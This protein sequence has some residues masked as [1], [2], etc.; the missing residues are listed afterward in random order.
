MLRII[1]KAFFLIL[2]CSVSGFAQTIVEPV[3]IKWD[4]QPREYAITEDQTLS[5]F[6][7]DGASYDEANPHFPIYS[8]KI[9]LSTYGDLNPVLVNAQYEPINAPS[10]I[11]FSSIEDI[12]LN[13]SV[14]F[15]RRQPMGVVYF[16]PIRKNPLNGQYERLTSA[17]L[18]INITP[19][20]SPY[21]GGLSSSR[22]NV[23]TSKFADGQI[24]K[25]SIS[26]TGVYKIDYNFLK[27]LGVNVDNIDPRNIQIL[28]NGG[29]ILPE[30][31][32]VAIP[33]DI[34]ENAIFVSGQADG[35]FDAND[36]ILF[37]GIG[38]KNWSFNN[39]A[40]C[41]PFTHRINPYTDDSHYFIKIGS[42][43]GKRLTSNQSL[44]STNYTTTSY[45]ALAHHEVDDVNLMEQEF[46]LPPSGRLW[47]G[48]SFQTQNNRSRT[49]N[50]PF[51][52]RIEGE[53]ITIKSNLAVRAFSTGVVTMRANNNIVGQP[54]ASPFTTQ[55]IYTDYAKSL[56]IPCNSITVNNQ[57]IDIRIDFDHP[58]TAA[59]MWLNYISL[60]AR[61]QLQFT[62]GQMDF[63]DVQSVGQGSA[64]YQLSGASNVTIWDITDPYDV[65][66]QE[67]NANG[68]NINFGA[69]ATDLHQFVAFDNS[70][71]YTPTARGSVANQNLHGITTPPDAIFVYYGGT[72]DQFD[73]QEQTERLA[74]HRRS[75]SN[76]TVDVINVQDIYNEFS[77]GNP[78]ITAIRN[79]CKL[80][81]ERETASN[82]FTHL[83]LF[84]IG[85]FDYKN[86]GDT[87]D[88]SNNPNLI[89]VYET[90]ESLHP[91]NTYTSDDYFAL[92]DTLERMSNYGLL[93]IAVGRLPAANKDEAK[94]FVDKIIK[95]DTDPAFM[96]DWKNRL[97][98]MADDGDNNLHLNDAESVIGS[99]LQNDNTFNIEKVYLDA[100]RSVSTSG[101]NRYPDAKNALLDVIFKG[102][103]V[104]NY[105]GHGGDD[106]WTQE[107]VFTSPDVEGLTNG[108]KLPLFIT[109]TC[110]FGPHDDPTSVSAGELLL[111]NP[112]GGAISVFTT[113]RVVIASHNK[114]LV[115]H[116][117]RVIFK[118]KADG[119]M[120]TT[121]EVM[122]FAKNNA[123]ISP[124]TN[125]RK[126]AL[127]GDP[128]MSLAYPTYNVRTDS[129]NGEVVGTTDTI[130][131]LEKVTISGSIVDD[132]N[133]VN[134]NFSGVIYPT[135]Y[136]KEDRLY[137]L[138][139][140][141]SSYPTAFLV[142]KKI[143]FKGKASVKNGKFS[144]T[145]VVPKDI[146]YSIGLGKIS[147]YAENT[148]TLD[149]KGAYFDLNVGGSYNNAVVDNQGPD[150]KVYM[151]TEDFVRGGITDNNPNLLVELYDENGINTVGNSIGHDLTGKLTTPEGQEE[152]YILNDFYESTQ[153]DYTSGT[154]IYPLKNLQP[155]LHTIK[156]KAWD[157]Y[158]NPGEGDTEFVVAESADL[159]LKHVLNYP[160]PF[161]TSTNF[162]FEHNYPYQSLDVQV[163]IYTVSG[164]L[165]K[166]INHNVNAEGNTGYRVTD[167]HWDG[168]DDYGDRLGKGVYIYKIFVQAED[169]TDQAKQ[170]SEF[171]KLVILK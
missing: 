24:Y 152:E 70:N 65:R 36:Y 155:G 92:L 110:S 41:G 81:Y 111:L 12:Q 94:I 131:A 9:E 18:R 57:D 42:Q 105:L 100:F 87:R 47:Y 108:Q 20:T 101:G 93:D 54:I 88:P 26:Q 130:S 2:F 84:G 126:Y 82:K 114:Q 153:D 121:G 144:F 166:T 32:N 122:Q 59:D 140:A 67:Y 58:S 168:L 129:I 10:N 56:T 71:F 143:I 158:N 150:V 72:G 147:Y 86:I 125:S 146:N 46:A 35:S 30:L 55:Q 139:N 8:K 31:M 119:S 79:F 75:H 138:G 7:F 106:G 3:T 74:A 60:Q 14:S 118:E 137:T 109:A 156:V 15:Q 19:K 124:P 51:R 99:A 116:T 53:P 34:M 73:L 145:F 5:Y 103:F 44:A 170:N 61:C 43:P 76:M 62:G 161:T 29:D 1:S 6:Y 39:N 97:C 133:I 167:I 78:D 48:E 135:V 159:A 171:Q 77:S 112:F 107:R 127:L 141:S 23:T 115:D 98:F 164:R 149:A 52:N 113:L 154:V 13:S 95:Y 66:I 21:A 162:Q 38:T 128:T 40:V 27:D 16:N 69:N 91:I 142:R 157:V 104:V 64:T 83:L 120:P 4:E 11:D 132:N 50:F 163:Q 45:D 136:D 33:D 90:I 22:N 68:G 37:Y 102:S 25:I 49:F 63:R 123:G 28:G 80:L 160:N 96:R 134:Q 169:T 148:Q 85:T 151:N 117:F 89:P 17:D 165:V